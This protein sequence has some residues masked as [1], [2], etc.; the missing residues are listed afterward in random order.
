MKEATKKRVLVNKIVLTLATLSAVAGLMFLGWILFVLAYNG[1]EALNSNIF[2]YDGAPPGYKESGLRH[3]LVGQAMLVVTAT[4]IGVPAGLLAGTYLSEYG[5]NSKF[6]NFIRDISDIMMSAP[7]IVIGAFVY[8]ILVAPVGHFNGWAGSCALAIMMIPIILRTTD[9]ML[10]LVPQTLREAAAALGA[11]KYKV[12]LQVV[13]RG[14]KTGI[15]TGILLSIARIAGET[16]PLLFTS[17]SNSFFSTD[18]NQPI[19][20]LTV[21]IY[22]YATSPYADWQKLGWAAA[23]I[24][25]LFVLGTNI[26]GR[27]IIKQRKR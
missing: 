3:A 19:A 2:I 9:D 23:F 18:M 4:L 1:I 20:S 13:Y 14:A 6:A 10:S 21:T 15:I 8:A 25:A 26:I 17:F 5:Q 24:L 7:S 11:P 12:I 22:N 27:L 16:A